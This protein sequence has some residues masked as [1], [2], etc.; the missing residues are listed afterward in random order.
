MVIPIQG[1]WEVRGSPEPS[2]G[3]GKVFQSR[4][5]WDRELQ[6]IIGRHHFGKREEHPSRV[7]LCAKGKK[8]STDYVYLCG[9]RG[10][11]AL[12]LSLR[13]DSGKPPKGRVWNLQKPP[14]DLHFSAFGEADLAPYGH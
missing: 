7:L 3:L 6:D 10:W 2:L 8:C 1:L 5:G 13:E 4:C 11:L 14:S 12:Q 9:H